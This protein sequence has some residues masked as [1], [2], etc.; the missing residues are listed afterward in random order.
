MLL[1]A[2]F[3]IF[4]ILKV[5]RDTRKHVNYVEVFPNNKC[6]GWK[7]WEIFPLCCI[8]I[9]RGTESATQRMN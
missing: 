4:Y 7:H 1:V 9:I 6:E 5:Y 3:S 8:D 2:Y